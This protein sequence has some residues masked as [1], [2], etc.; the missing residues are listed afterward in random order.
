MTILIDEWLSEELAHR[1]RA[2]GHVDATHVRWI[3]KGGSKDW[4][5]RQVIVEGSYLFVTMNSVDF[6]GRAVDP[7]SAGEHSKIDLHAGLICLDGPPGMDWELS[8]EL[9]EI[10]LDE[11]E[12]D[13]DLANM[14]LDVMWDGESER[15]E[16]PDV[17]GGSQV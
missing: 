13:P 14:A 12:R 17:S 2:R 8:L 5:L 11:L 6:R 1:D 15:I 9:F 16:A 7:G 10:A 4:Q 3:G